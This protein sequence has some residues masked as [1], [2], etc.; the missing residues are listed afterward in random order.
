MA[1]VRQFVILSEG[2]PRTR[3]ADAPRQEAGPNPGPQTS[4]A[5]ERGQA[6][7]GRLQ[8]II[9]FLKPDKACKLLPPY[10]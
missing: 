2:T 4:L 8:G 10:S 7:Q 9:L 5:P 1:V 6:R 3:S